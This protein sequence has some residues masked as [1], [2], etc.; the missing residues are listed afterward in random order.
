MPAG[1]GILQERAEARDQRIARLFRPLD[2]DRPGQGAVMIGQ[3]D[4]RE[5]GAAVDAG[6]AEV[7]DQRHADDRQ[8]LELVGLA[9]EQ[10]PV[11]RHVPFAIGLAETDGVLLAKPRNASPKSSPS[12]AAKKSISIRLRIWP[13]AVS[14]FDLMPKRDWL[15]WRKTNSSSSSSNRSAPGIEKENLFALPVTS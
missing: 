13:T 2:A 6:V 3:A 9:D 4:L 8:R 10:G 12:L 7:I 14:T 1:D 5:A 11:R 15:A